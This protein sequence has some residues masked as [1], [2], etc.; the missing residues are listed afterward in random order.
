MDDR[1]V[2]KLFE[3]IEIAVAMQWGVLI[4][5]ANVAIDNL[6]TD[7]DLGACPTPKRTEH[8]SLTTNRSDA[9]P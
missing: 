8:L 7:A 2:E 3:R 9:D 6:S 1:E 4:A 5:D